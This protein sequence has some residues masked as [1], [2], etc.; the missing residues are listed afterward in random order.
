MF[1][2]ESPAGTNED[3]PTNYT[4]QGTTLLAKGTASDFAL[5]E[6]PNRFRRI[7]MCISP[8]G[9]LKAHR[10]LKRSAFITQR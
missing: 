5:L 9:A 10:R 2:Y 7:T 1:N 3:G 8:V 4:V 6:I